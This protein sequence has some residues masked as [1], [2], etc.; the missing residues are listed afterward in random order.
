[1]KN[2]MKLLLC[3][4]LVICMALSMVACGGEKKDEKETDPASESADNSTDTEAIA[5][6]D[7]PTGSFSA[8]SLVPASSFEE[9]V[10]SMVENL[11]CYDVEYSNLNTADLFFG[12]CY[13]ATVTDSTM[14]FE[15]DYESTA[16]IYETFKETLTNILLEAL[17]IQA[18]IYSV[19]WEEMQQACMEGYGMDINDYLDVLMD[20]LDSSFGL[21]NIENFSMDYTAADGTITADGETREYVVEDGNVY[22]TVNGELVLTLIT[23]E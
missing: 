2:T 7:F 4:M 19:S 11:Q 9:L 12:A 13:D 18:D 17:R 1:M 8:C 23:N 15:Y 20:S 10:M 6:S 21:E 16:A 22:I 5:A 14:S 3:L